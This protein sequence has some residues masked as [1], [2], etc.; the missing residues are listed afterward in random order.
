MKRKKKQVAKW[1][2][3][4]FFEYTTLKPIS[5]N[6]YSVYYPNIVSHFILDSNLTLQTLIEGQ[7]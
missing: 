5:L 4:N 6:L 2:T 7:N 1:V 3:P